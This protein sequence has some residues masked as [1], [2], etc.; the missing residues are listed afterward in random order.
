MSGGFERRKSADERFGGLRA[1]SFRHF[2]IFDAV[3]FL[4]TSQTAL[5]LTLNGYQH[6]IKIAGSSQKR[7]DIQ[8]SCHDDLC[9]ARRAFVQRSNLLTDTFGNDPIMK[10]GLAHVYVDELP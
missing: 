10:H 1:N 6:R 2:V 9:K 8:C 5:L 3:L 7:T 4:E